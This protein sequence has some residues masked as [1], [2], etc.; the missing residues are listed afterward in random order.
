MAAKGGAPRWTPEQL[1][2]FN[3]RTTPKVLVPVKATTPLERFR[4]LGRLP[5]GKMNKTEA[6]YAEELERQRQL[7]IIR[8][9]KFHP[10]NIRLA[11]RAFYEVDFLVFHGDGTLAIHETKGSY[12]T[13]KGQLKI[14]LA[15]EAMPWFRFFKCIKLSAK[16]GGGFKVEEYNK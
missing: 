7:G 16:D 13:D 10:M 11:D 1:A 14:R 4:A 9:W 15:A 12:T 6:Q 5:K 8:D 3:A 2:A